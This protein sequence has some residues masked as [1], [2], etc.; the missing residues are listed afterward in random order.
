MKKLFLAIAAL[1][2]LAV[3]LKLNNFSV[4]K[5]NVPTIE[6]MVYIPAGK[7]TMGSQNGRID[8]QPEHKI[9]LNAFY[10]DKYE[11]TNAQYK[12]FVDATG[13]PAPYLDPEKYPWAKEYNWV[14]GSYP[15]GMG[16]YPVVLV[17]WED[18]AA[19]AKWAGKRL[20]TEAE[21]EKAA[22]GTDKRN[23]P[24]G[25]EWD[26]TKCNSRESGYLRAMPVDSF[27]LGRS[28]YGVY[29]MAGNVWEWC[30]DWYDKDYYD[31][32]PA[33]NPQ[34]PD[35]GATKVIRGGSWDTFGRNRLT[36]FARE[37]QFPS[38]K[39]YDIGFRCVKEAELK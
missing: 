12:E 39:S 36:T 13:H 29:N 19:Y 3:F 14:N 9:F 38:T 25:N 6:G 20:P 2:L 35:V 1:I 32:S 11:V 26:V 24:W 7:F 10:I 4:A 28:P 37:S 21:W 27:G 18:A 23:Y 5:N 33:K 34:G 15:E 16:N 22:R 8:A 17:S 31:K 30:A